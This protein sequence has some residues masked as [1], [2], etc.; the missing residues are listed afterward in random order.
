MKKLII[1]SISLIV[2]V[3][4]K[5]EKTL[6]EP[7]KMTTD[8]W[9]KVSDEYIQWYSDIKIDRKKSI[10]ILSGSKYFILDSNLNTI[11]KYEDIGSASVSLS[12]NEFIDESNFF[13]LTNYNNDS[14]KF[15]ISFLK[16][17]DGKIWS[18]TSINEDDLFGSYIKNKRVHSY[19]GSDNSPFIAYTYIE[20]FI[21][22]SSYIFGLSRFNNSIVSKKITSYKR[23]E[24]RVDQFARLGNNFVFYSNYGN[25]IL[26]VEENGNQIKKKG[27]MIYNGIKN[28][29]RLLFNHGD[30]IIATEDGMNFY[31]VIQN[32]ELSGDVNKSPNDS[33]LVIS[34][35]YKINVINL[36]T[37]SQMPFDTKG[38]LSYYKSP[39]FVY[40]NKLVL[41][42]YDGIYVR[43]LR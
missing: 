13:S 17:N 3:G 37:K 11:Y 28:G 27:Q 10:M 12:C 4:C 1:V 29:D 26:M 34:S 42:A 2:F 8:Q 23:P 31:D 18:K 9:T 16:L 7:N 40:F 6:V 43:P 22:D 5:K 15:L 32:I 24:Y 41:L 30:K 20:S 36:H 14:Y 25:E 35:L 38:V 39:C 21:S 33:L 19:I